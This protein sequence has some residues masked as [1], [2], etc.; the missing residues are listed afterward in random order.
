MGIFVDLERDGYSRSMLPCRVYVH[1]EPLSPHE[2]NPK[3]QSMKHES[4]QIFAVATLI[5]VPC[6]ANDGTNKEID[7]T[8]EQHVRPILR[9]NCFHCHGEGEEL[10][11]GLDLRLRRFIVNGGDSGPAL[12]P[13]GHDRSLLYQ[14]VRAREMPPGDKKLTED[15]V[16]LIARWIT[17]G[18]KVAGPEPIEL[19]PGFHITTADRDLWSIQPIIRPDIPK[20]REPRRV[21]TPLDAFLLTRLEEKGLSFSADQSPVIF[22]CRLKVQEMTPLDWAR[23]SRSESIRVKI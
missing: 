20:V 13:H 10:K 11:G 17:A 15:Q 14:R 2:I 7:L 19:V 9:V 4:W 22:E 23:A 6:L 3:V 16:E 21:R 1:G 5:G 8:Y 12:V 18:A